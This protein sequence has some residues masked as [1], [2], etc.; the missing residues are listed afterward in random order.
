MNHK[1]LE[2]NHYSEDRYT[3]LSRILYR[4][5]ELLY[6]K[7]TCCQTIIDVVRKSLGVDEDGT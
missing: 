2:R 4:E 1:R 3:E 6:D 5:N 7:E